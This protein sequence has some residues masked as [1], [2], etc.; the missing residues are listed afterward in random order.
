MSAAADALSQLRAAADASQ[1]HRPITSALVGTR[2]AFATTQRPQAVNDARA[3]VPAHVCHP[4][5]LVVS[6]AGR[7]AVPECGMPA[8]LPFADYAIL[9]AVVSD[10]GPA[11]DCDSCRA[12][13]STSSSPGSYSRLQGTQTRPASPFASCPE[14]GFL[15][16]TI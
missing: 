2:D 10:R 6:L 16:E 7:M 14:A 12:D 9:R 11:D 13:V 5:H 15:V 8:A 1:F 4:P 3:R